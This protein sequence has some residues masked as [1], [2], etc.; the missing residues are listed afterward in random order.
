[1]ENTNIPELTPEVVES[2]IEV[3][4]NNSSSM[5][6][7][8]SNLQTDIENAAD[9]IDPINHRILS[10][11]NLMNYSRAVD[12]SAI[13]YASLGE[14]SDGQSAEEFETACKQIIVD[15]LIRKNNPKYNFNC[16]ADANKSNL[17]AT[18]AFVVND[19]DLLEVDG[20]ASTYYVI[21]VISDSS[22]TILNNKYYIEVSGAEDIANGSM[23]ELFILDGNELISAELFAEISENTTLKWKGGNPHHMPGSHHNPTVVHQQKIPAMEKIA[24][25]LW[26]V[27]GKDYV[28]DTTYYYYSDCCVKCVYTWRSGK[29]T[30]SWAC[31]PNCYNG[32]N[33]GYGA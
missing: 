16:Y 13:T 31:D 33:G 27:F 28:V 24:E 15:D 18:A 10:E 17:I 30:Y 12:C 19:Y 22:N 25:F 11:H 7:A 21:K 2:A 9:D 14:P 23:L 20:L 4:S 29:V 1:M 32:N 26:D 3:L 8:V 5:L 6:S